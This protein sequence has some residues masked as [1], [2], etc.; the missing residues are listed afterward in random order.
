MRK[1]DLRVPLPRPLDNTTRAWIAEHIAPNAVTDA[2]FPT[3]R[4]T[5]HADH[6]EVAEPGQTVSVHIRHAAGVLDFE[7][8]SPV[9]IAMVHTSKKEVSR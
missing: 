6:L 7:L 3:S 9:F 1:T 2:P 8:L 5:L 4:T